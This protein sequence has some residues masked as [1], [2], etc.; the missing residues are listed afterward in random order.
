MT[1]TARQW[2][3]EVRKSEVEREVA[4]AAVLDCL[5]LHI[6]GNEDDRELRLNPI[7]KEPIFRAFKCSEKRL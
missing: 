4:V 3:T 5:C 7:V 1:V 6:A 2:L